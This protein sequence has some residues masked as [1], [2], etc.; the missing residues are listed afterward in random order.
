MPTQQGAA[1]RIASGT[2]MGLVVGTVFY[3]L[4]SIYPNSG[5]FFLSSTVPVYLSLRIP[6]PTPL[7]TWFVGYYA[8]VGLGISWLTS[9]QQEKMFRRLGFCLTILISIHYLA[10][11]LIAAEIRRI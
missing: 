11:F 10:T 6:S 7:W 4:T 1:F 9:R 5:M 2:L 8:V 3:W